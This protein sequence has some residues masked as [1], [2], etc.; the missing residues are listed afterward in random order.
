MKP[1]IS[2]INTIPAPLRQEF[3]Q[4]YTDFTKSR[5][6][7]LCA[8]TLLLY[9]SAS[10]ISNLMTP[11]EFRPSELP[12]MA[13]LFI[14]SMIIFLVNARTRGFI[15][16]KI[17]AHVFS[18]FLIITVTKL[19]TVYYESAYLSASV[20]MLILFLIS[21]TIPWMPAETVVITLFEFAAYTAFYFYMQRYHPQT[22]FDISSYVE[23]FIFL[24][25][26]G[27]IVLAIRSR[28]FKREAENFIM[29]KEIKGKNEL[30]QRELELATKIHSTLIPRSIVTEKVDIGVL[31][32]PA[33]YMGGDYAQ[34]TFLDKEKL[35]FI[36]CD[37]T[38]HGVSAALIVNRVHTEFE[39][40]AR[41]VSGPGALLNNLNSFILHDFKG[42]NMY[43]SAFCGLLD[44][45]NNKFIYSNHGHPTQYLF[46]AREESLL[47]FDPHAVILGIPFSD[48]TVAD[49]ELSFQKG[50]K[51]IMFTD[52]VT[53]TTNKN[54]EEYGRIR[55]ED[56]I[57]RNYNKKVDIFN[58]LLLDEL[59]V[60]KFGEFRDD[61][62]LL[63]L[64][65]KQLSN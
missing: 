20:Y 48:E 28:E 5:I 13:A 23:G 29:M 61:I 52:G 6:R 50:D 55:L 42:T 19:L 21:F 24:Y 15:P 16:A 63:A 40:L 60:F 7:F 11:N 22:G 51:I 1:I 44:F 9:V 26:S 38:G 49:K 32:L 62:F 39:K 56:F 10:L 45:R 3:L 53:E 35:I 54:L 14:G 37:V 31:Y 33:Y 58:S 46:R 4:N 2:I 27:I 8:M 12:V 43:L 64:D 65:I 36:I 41:T 34:F 25:I 18:V 59:N 47:G 57:K 17:I 30:M